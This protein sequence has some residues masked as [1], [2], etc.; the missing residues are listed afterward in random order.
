MYRTDNSQSSG[1]I[2]EQSIDASLAE[3]ENSTWHNLLISSNGS[4]DERT[5]RKEDSSASEDLLSA[6]STEIFEASAE[7]ADILNAL[8]N[9]SVVNYDS[10]NFSFSESSKE[11]TA[12]SPNGHDLH[13]RFVQLNTELYHAK[14]ELLTYKYKWNEIRH[15]VELQWNK[16]Y[17]RIEDEK[18][19][20]EQQIG[21]LKEQLEKV[22]TLNGSPGIQHYFSEVANFKTD[23]GQLKLQLDCKDQANS[24][25][26]QKLAEQYCDKERQ[27][28]ELRKLEKVLLEIRN[29]LASARKAEEWFRNE[30][31]ACQ[32]T[33]TKL[34]ENILLLQNRGMQYKQR[35][36]QLKFD[37]QQAILA[38]EDAERNAV[39]EKKE[40]LSKLN[41]I[42]N[43]DKLD[44]VSGQVLSDYGAKLK[45]AHDKIK[46]LTEV[47]NGYEHEKEQ[48][49]FSIKVLNNTLSNQDILTQTYK[50]K[51]AQAAS[52]ITS[53][54]GKISRLNA[55]IAQLH[56]KNEQ[57]QA[58]IAR[59][60]YTNRD[61]DVSIGHLQAQLKVLSINFES[62]RQALSVK[63]CE[64]K[65]LQQ[66]HYGLK[67]HC[68]QQLDACRS[69]W[70][71]RMKMT[72]SQAAKRYEQLLDN[73]RKIQ[74]KNLDLEVKLGHYAEHNEKFQKSEVLVK[75][76]KQD[77][78]ELQEKVVQDAAAVVARMTPKE[79]R[80]SKKKTCPKHGVAIPEDDTKNLKILLK[81]IE[82]EHRHKLKRYELNNRTLLKKVK[83]HNHARKVAEQKLESIQRDLVGA[84]SLQCDLARLRERNLLLEADLESSQQECSILKNEKCRL[85]ESLTNNGLLKAE[86]DIWRTFQRISQELRDRQHMQKENQRFKEMLL[87]SEAK[88][89]Q[90]E[91]ELK[92]SLSS[93]E[94]KSSVIENL[95]LATELQQ[96][97]SGEIRSALTVKSMQLEDTHRVINDLNSERNSLQD[98]LGGKQLN[99]EKLLEEM[100]SLQKQLKLRD[101]QL[102][103]ACKRLKLHED[104]EKTLIQS[105]HGFYKNLQLLRE[106]IVTEKQEKQELQVTIKALKENF[107]Q[108]RLCEAKN[109]QNNSQPDSANIS[110]PSMDTNSE[111]PDLLPPKSLAEISFN[112]ET[113]QN[114][115]AECY[116]RDQSLHPLQESIASL[117]TEM[118]HLNVLVRQ[119]SNQRYPVVSLMEELQDATNG[120]YSSR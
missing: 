40:L 2:K 33:N 114:L 113:L 30:L 86:E 116:R 25:L 61:L 62:T 56:C 9:S 118:S 76:L 74:S 75:Q 95:K 99:E 66:E 84:H 39:K 77:I 51:E 80:P 12:I 23:L 48:L 7:R 36:T 43:R 28:I 98:T 109:C 89:H 68:Q 107:S 3:A 14:T 115:I 44:T 106:E 108:F 110:I 19:D 101:V 13:Q 57:L 103:T 102:E 53:L 8:Q 87:I 83:E 92:I 79:G 32:N 93:L 10:G 34:R 1:C 45:E 46:A 112:E 88:V 78:D 16:K 69:D 60:S 27:S 65:K 47:S 119:N 15:E 82:N 97:E 20:L 63:E 38:R 24:I 67:E 91:E 73:F 6:A 104:S 81:V 59:Y 17:Q 58:A 31:H 105:M 120:V 49:V 11:K 71:T 22:I 117:R 29:E 96:V 42:E 4:F 111:P 5:Q 64:L 41:S 26:K 35:N 37:L 21:E 100:N 70:E 72:E 85:L 18:F 90:L 55:E 50:N 54:Q 94:E 52:T